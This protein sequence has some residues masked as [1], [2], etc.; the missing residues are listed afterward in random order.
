MA[1]KITQTKIIVPLERS[2]KMIETM[3]KAGIDLGLTP[4]QAFQVLRPTNPEHIRERVVGTAY[5]DKK[6]KKFVS[7][8][9]ARKIGWDNISKIKV[10]AKYVPG[11][12][13][14]LKLISIF[15]WNWRSEITKTE[16]TGK[17]IA[18][19]IRLWYKLPNGDWNYIEKTGGAAFKSGI[20]DYNREKAAE[21][22]AFKR[23]C[24]AL[25]FFADVYA[26]MLAIEDRASLE[27]LKEIEIE[28]NN[29]RIVEP[30]NQPKKKTYNPKPS[31]DTGYRKSAVVNPK[32]PASLKQKEYINTMIDKL[33]NDYELETELELP[34]EQLNKGQAA[35]LI[36]KLLKRGK[37]AKNNIRKEISTGEPPSEENPKE[38]ER[39]GSIY[40]AD[41]GF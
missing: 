17:E 39:D 13:F 1:K 26:P 6:T 11:R 28:E 38:P 33:R 12:I 34:V 36:E 14:E 7:Y 41:K 15:G 20:D 40:D 24:I 5:Q 8:N 16:K 3:E 25:G 4:R 29:K 2:E 21:T 32:M 35:D 10:K 23:C 19:T 31:E 27:G 9:E 22:D 18:K 30:T 37:E